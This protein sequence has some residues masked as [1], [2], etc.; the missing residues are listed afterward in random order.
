[1]GFP[2]VNYLSDNSRTEGELK[3]ALEDLLK[4][5]KQ[6]P[7]A[8]VAAQALTIS[9][10]SVTPA[11]GASQILVIDTEAAAASDDLANIVTTNLG[12][13]SLVRVKIANDARLVTV[14]HA[15]G[16]AGQ[17]SLVTGGDFVLGDTSHWIDFYV[18]GT[19]LEEIARF[20]S[21]GSVVSSKSGNYTVTVADRGDLIECTATLTLS[22]P[23]A[24]TAG[25][26]FDLLVECAGGVTTIDPSGAETIGGASTLLLYRGDKVRITCTG[27]AWK[28]VQ[29]TSAQVALD[30]YLQGF[31]YQPNGSDVAND[32]DVA[33]G[34]ALDSTGVYVLRGAALTKRLD[35][36]WAVGTNAGMLDTGAVGNND[37]FLW[38]I[39]RSD[40]G[41]VDYLASLSSSAPTMPANYDFKRLIGWVKRSAGANVAWKTYELAGGGLEFHWTAS[42]LDV[43]LT[44]TL[45][46]TRRL[47][48]LSVPNGLSV[49][50]M[51]NVLL[52][53]GASALY[54]L[55]QCPDEA[56]AAPNSSAAPGT[57]ARIYNVGQVGIAELDVRT[58]TSR[59]IAAR[60]SSSTFNT[61]QVVTRGFKWSRR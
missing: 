29:R 55:I 33:A 7:G 17:L 32:V 18:N 38:V 42:I 50:A 49:A 45:T 9:A 16:G 43:Y 60:A 34:V 3:V 24:A 44:G 54:A 48:A 2:A 35:A 41:V 14:K 10:G 4:A 53:D 27:T 36:V 58:N 28:I 47:D 61:Y 39:G 51:I 26:G 57:N 25:K 31:T 52:N 11:L 40:T 46:T 15:A 19:Q 12:P 59:Q 20:P 13:N 21:A 5:C 1:M 56:D 37:Y 23:A 22:L 6:I 30:Q 8:G